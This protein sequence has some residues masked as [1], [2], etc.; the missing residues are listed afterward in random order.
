MLITE[1]LPEELEM[2]G[3]GS[4]RVRT[5]VQGIEKR[6]VRAN[7]LDGDKRI[8]E[9]DPMNL[10]GMRKAYSLYLHDLHSFHQKNDVDMCFHE[11]Q[12][13]SFPIHCLRCEQVCF[14]V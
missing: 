11:E 7:G 5:P 6:E 14:L 13:D 8:V 3:R 4:N 10:L 2:V 1:V 12:Q 9:H